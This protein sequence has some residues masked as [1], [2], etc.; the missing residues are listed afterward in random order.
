[1]SLDK[2]NSDEEVVEMIRVKDKELFSELIN[3]YEAKLLRYATYLIHDPDRAADAV[4]GAFIKAYINLN[5][6]DVKKKFSSWI[7]RIV[8]NEVMNALKKY[9]F[10]FPLLE[11]MDFEDKTK[12][13]ENYSREEITKKINQCLGKLP[14]HYAEPVTLHFLEEKTYEEIS[15]IMRIPMGTVAIRINRAKKI[16]KNLC[17]TD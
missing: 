4:Q 3:R 5:R 17:R 15:S 8:H 14:A 13:E 10:E 12:M 16:L 7:Y 6:F 9:R 1:M 2:K 11:E